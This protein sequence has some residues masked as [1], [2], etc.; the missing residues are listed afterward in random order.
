MSVA[1]SSCTIA[2][3]S[4]QPH[5]VITTLR[6]TPCGRGGSGGTSPAAMRSVQSAKSCSARSRP[7]RFS[8]LFM[9]G[10]LRPTC[11]R[12][13]QAATVESKS[14]TSIIGISRVAMLPIWWQSWQPSFSRSTHSAWCRMPRLMPLPLGPVP[15]NSSAAGT[16]SSE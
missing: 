1:I 9:L 5:I 6:S 10:P 16:S 11:T 15:G 13:S 12:W 2:I 8:P 4:P 14:S 3:G 7:I